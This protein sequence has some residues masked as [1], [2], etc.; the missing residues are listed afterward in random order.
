[1][2]PG[3]PSSSELLRATVFHTPG[4]PF[5]RT[6]ALEA[7]SDGG[8]LIEK[9][10][11]AAC[12][13]YAEVCTA[14]PRASTRDLR[15]GFLLPGFIDAHVHYPQIRILGALGYSLLEW[16]EKQTLPEEAKFA[17][18][19]YA[20]AVATE[21]VRALLSRGTTTAL[22]FGSHFAPATALLFE[23]AHKTGLRIVSGLV[24]SDRLLRP[25]LH[26]SGEIA[27]LESRELIRRFHGQ[28]NAVYAVSPRFA[29]S[30]SE[31]SPG[32]LPDAASRTSRG[33]SSDPPERECPRD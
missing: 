23:A 19:D 4:S 11:I 31:G 28:G 12:G 6:H 7:F 15:G 33:A 27:Y 17:D 1:M 9:G 21:F 3:D 2:T 26:A 22:V 5:Q 8:L 29:L 18:P 32:S 10:R 16:L 30:T 20:Q 14:C 13:D 24:L 25:D